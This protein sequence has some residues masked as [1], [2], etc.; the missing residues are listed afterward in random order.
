MILAPTDEVVNSWENEI[1]KWYPD[2]PYVTLL[3][4]TEEKWERFDSID[5]GL[6]IATYVGI[7]FMVSTLQPA[8]DKN[9]NKLVVDPRKLPDLVADMKL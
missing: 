7:A 8:K 1:K 5:S 6:V 9:K 3:G 4:S 2:L